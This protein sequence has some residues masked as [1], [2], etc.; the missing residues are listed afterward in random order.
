MST[1][2]IAFPRGLRFT[3]RAVSAERALLLVATMLGAATFW[4]APR[5]PMVDLPQHAGQ[6]AVWRDLLLGVSPF[7]AD[8]R[9]SLFTPYLIG[10]AL[11]LPLAFIMEPGEAI[12]VVMTLAFPAFVAA[13]RSL[14]RELGG[15]P[16]VDWLFLFGFFGQAW[17][18]GFYTFLVAAPATLWMIRF[19]ARF[20]AV[21][22][23]RRGAALVG[24]GL[25][26][27]FC[28]GLQF[29]FA[30]AAGTAIVLERVIREARQQG[31]RAGVV[32]GL[33]RVGPFVLLALA[34]L[35]FMAIRSALV[36]PDDVAP[37]TWPGPPIWLRP[38]TVITFIW[39]GAPDPALLVITLLALLAPLG[40]NLAPARGP[41]LALLLLVV[42]IGLFGVSSAMYTGF[43]YERFALYVAPFWALSLKP[44]SSTTRARGGLPVLIVCAFAAL[45]A[46]AWRIVAFAREDRDFT[47][48]LD[49]VAPGERGISLI[50]EKTA[51]SAGS[52]HV[53]L[54]WGGWAQAARG[55]FV[56]F[57]FANFAPQIV[58]FRPDKVPPVNRTLPPSA[59]DWLAWGAS[60]YDVFITHGTQADKDAYLLS[61]APCAL[62][63]TATAGAWTLYRKSAACAK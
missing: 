22:S 23:L 10:Y 53:Y 54:H 20:D 49:A 5:L 24:C 12:R 41:G 14:R 62:T 43:L 44:G 18:W 28:H 1:D 48:I 37:V 19:A 16:R 50:Y 26:L 8:L 55:A 32:A 13:A 25:V 17:N 27:L 33:R 40:M 6:I 31:A 2:T 9:I 60:G 45:A 36:G 15:D 59:F 51:P 38:L 58:R 46:H 34:F 30:G 29:L 61:R 47:R 21:P 4:L 56:D 57:N 63:A 39:S 35:A 3:P 52:D 7:S 11:A 42:A